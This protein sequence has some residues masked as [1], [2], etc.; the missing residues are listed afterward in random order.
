MLFGVF[1]ICIYRVIIYFTLCVSLCVYFQSNFHYFS[2][3]F[4]RSSYLK[5]C[6]DQ[7]RSFLL[8]HAIYSI[9]IYPENFHHTAQK[10]IFSANRWNKSLAIYMIN[11]YDLASSDVLYLITNGA[12]NAL[13]M[14]ISGKNWFIYG[15][16]WYM[17]TV[18]GFT[19]GNWRIYIYVNSEGTAWRSKFHT[20][21]LFI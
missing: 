12:N 11:S 6:A 17:Q 8:T 7:K 16:V 21:L 18:S 15:M 9:I 14:E 5:W 3:T 10:L 19:C 4:C 13:K 20:I 1:C 2:L